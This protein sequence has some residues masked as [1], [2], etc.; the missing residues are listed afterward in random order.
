LG[1]G[2]GL[3]GAII[4]EGFPTPAEEDLH[5]VPFLCTGEDISIP[6]PRA[7]EEISIP[8]PDVEPIAGLSI[9]EIP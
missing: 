7:G 6:L 9:T 1:S 8:I 3:A 5:A 2:L 4:G